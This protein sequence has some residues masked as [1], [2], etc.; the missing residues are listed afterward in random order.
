MTLKSLLSKNRNDLSILVGNGINQ[1]N[2][3]KGQNSW[4]DLLGNLARSYLLPSYKGLPKGITHTE[5]YDVLELAYGRTKGEP[6]LVAQFMELMNGWKPMEQHRAITYWAKSH[7]VP[8]LTTNFENTMGEASESTFRRFSN[9][10]FTHVYP[11]ET[12]YSTEDVSAPSDQFAIWH[13]NGMARY[14][15]SIRLGLGHYM[16]SVKRAH[17]WIHQGSTR[18][19][20]DPGGA[21]W[22]GSKTWLQIFFHKPLLIMGQGLSETEVFLRWLLLERAK[23]FNIHPHLRQ[24][25]WFIHTPGSLRAGQEMFLRAVGIEPYEVADYD[26][27]YSNKTWKSK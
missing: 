11:W 9:P 5:F 18:L 23:Y 4:D 21:K 6:A 27:I 25:S 19:F 7:N 16:G 3:A 2:A 8:I 22:A 14:Q 17:G 26:A 10:H 24:A 12:Y 1:Y 13:I 15:T 20:G